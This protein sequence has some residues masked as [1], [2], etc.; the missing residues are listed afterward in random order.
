[1]ELKTIGTFQ[2]AMI[3]FQ[4]KDMRRFSAYTCA[5]FYYIS[6]AQG[7]KES[8]WN[9]T[10]IER[11]NKPTRIS[12]RNNSLNIVFRHNKLYHRTDGPAVISCGVSYFYLKGV[13]L[14]KS[15]W[16]CKVQALRGSS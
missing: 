16:E 12:M 2:D 7:F 11:K 10:M 1:M 3:T 4:K 9:D 8:G 14:S 13:L 6:D 5:K 15:D